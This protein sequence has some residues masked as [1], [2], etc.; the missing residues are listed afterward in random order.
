[1]RIQQVEEKVLNA[2]ETV[3]AG[4]SVEDSRI[5][6]KSDWPSVDKVRQLAGHANAARGETIIWII[7]IDEK[8][9]RS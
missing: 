7:G 5:E 2:V 4:G 3:L 1:M 8:R 6:C 9:I